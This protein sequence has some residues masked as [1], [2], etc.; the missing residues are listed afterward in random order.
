MAEV[1][2]ILCYVFV[3]RT[4]YRTFFLLL[5][6]VFSGGT[7]ILAI[8]DRAAKARLDIRSVMF[9]DCDGLLKITATALHRNL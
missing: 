7:T 5:G 1:M 3:M 8:P 4:S 6:F 9:E 2:E